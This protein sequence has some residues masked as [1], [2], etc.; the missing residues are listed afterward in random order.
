MGSQGK[1]RRL[2]ATHGASTKAACAGYHWAGPTTNASAVSSPGTAALHRL[3]T[4]S[5]LDGFTLLSRQVHLRGLSPSQRE[6]VG[7]ANDE[8]VLYR[9]LPGGPTPAGAI[10]LWE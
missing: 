7:Q 1:G 10:L 8:H 2:K 5:R 9:R 6:H 4:K 3:A